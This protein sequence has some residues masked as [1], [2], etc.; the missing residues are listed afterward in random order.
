MQR[1][2]SKRK[3]FKTGVRAVLGLPSRTALSRIRLPDRGTTILQV[4]SRKVVLKKAIATMLTMSTRLT[5]LMMRTRQTVP[6]MPRMAMRPRIPRMVMMPTIPM[7]PTRPTIPMV[8]LIAT[9]PMMPMIA[10]EARIAKT[11]KNPGPGLKR[12][13]S[14]IQ[15][16]LISA[17]MAQPTMQAP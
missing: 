15:T 17:W 6:M 7:T 9:A 14:T 13:I 11:V 12:E 3:M 5:M 4:L 8:L 1:D 10:K 2:L 16:V